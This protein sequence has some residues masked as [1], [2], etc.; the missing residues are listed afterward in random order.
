M[1]SKGPQQEIPGVRP[2]EIGFDPFL[3][4]VVDP[5][6]DKPLQ[7]L[8]IRGR[9]GRSGQLFGGVQLPLVTRLR[10]DDREVRDLWIG[11]LDIHKRAALNDCDLVGD[12]PD[13]IDLGTE[14]GI[15]VG[16]EIRGEIRLNRCSSFRAFARDPVNVR[17]VLGPEGSRSSGIV[18]VVSLG[19]FAE[20]L[21]NRS[22]VGLTPNGHQHRQ[23]CDGQRVNRRPFHE[24]LIKSG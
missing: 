15:G 5:L 22:L 12:I 24:N 14:F 21:L 7:V 18:L 2:A 19:V 11:S 13:R 23:G 20:R 16:L 8:E 10:H 1:S 6:A 3:R 9:Y 17:R 4:G